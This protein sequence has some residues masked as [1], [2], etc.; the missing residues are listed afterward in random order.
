MSNF[1]NILFG[2]P[3]KTTRQNLKETIGTALRRFRIMSPSTGQ[4]LVT[5]LSE[6]SVSFP[7]G[8]GALNP[9]PENPRV[10]KSHFGKN[11]I[12]SSTDQ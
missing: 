9:Q 4:Q 12:T 1:L 5:E 7:F 3:F 2:T 6:D 10:A 8:R 11:L